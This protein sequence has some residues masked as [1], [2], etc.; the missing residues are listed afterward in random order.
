[1]TRT[2]AAAAAPAAPAAPC[3]SVS[4]TL[5]NEPGL[6][7]ALRAIFAFRSEESTL[8]D[9][10]TLPNDAR[11]KYEPLFRRV[12]H[13]AIVSPEST[14]QT[15]YAAAVAQCL[16][17]IAAIVKGTDYD[18]APRVLG[19][20]H[21]I[22]PEG[23]TTDANGGAAADTATTF[24][25]QVLSMEMDRIE[26]V[27]VEGSA[28]FKQGR[29]Q[30]TL[31]ATGV[32]W[33]GE[34]PTELLIMPRDAPAPRD[35]RPRQVVRVNR[36]T[37]VL[38]RPPLLFVYDAGDNAFEKNEPLRTNV[39]AYAV[40]DSVAQAAT[41]FV[42]DC[43]DQLRFVDRKQQDE[44][45]VRTALLYDCAS[46]ALSCAVASHHPETGEDG[47]I[48]HTNA[49]AV[50]RGTKQMSALLGEMW[51]A[52]A[53][54]RRVS[55]VPRVMS[56][57]SPTKLPP[58]YR[59][60]APILKGSHLLE[61]LVEDEQK[62]EATT[63]RLQTCHERAGLAAPYSLGEVQAYLNGAGGPCWRWA[64]HLLS[65]ALPA[66]VRSVAVCRREPFDETV[67]AWFVFDRG[68]QRHLSDAPDNSRI[69]WEVFEASSVGATF[70]VR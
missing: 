64:Y 4:M 70:R 55:V 44:W 53:L 32:P 29:M 51:I 50:F 31:R 18:A 21:E 48:H 33:I 67:G 54:Y 26:N 10:S 8:P 62:R 43:I 47:W 5:A 38:H 27:R 9:E 12:F 1:M 13:D 30:C 45:E 28:A 16:H 22:R 66:P 3:A 69:V 46:G 6:K 60:A 59:V 14:A 58:L 7:S 41:S 49:A 19:A 17:V 24:G 39:A 68:Y 56:V 35:A 25:M 42:A 2:R 40:T 34:A 65:L 52:A 63:M 11:R 36:R 61:L 37:R 15:M 57:P 20:L 23:A